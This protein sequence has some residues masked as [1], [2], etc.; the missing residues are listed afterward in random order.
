MCGDYLFRKVFGIVLFNIDTLKYEME[1]RTCGSTEPGTL[2]DFGSIAQR[3][4]HGTAQREQSGLA[5]SITKVCTCV[6]LY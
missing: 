1:M 5:T 4:Q 6:Y 3:A 2:F